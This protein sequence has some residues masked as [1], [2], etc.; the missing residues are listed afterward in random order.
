MMR[1]RAPMLALMS[2]LFPCLALG[3]GPA[4]NPLDAARSRYA[5]LDGIRVHYKSVGDSETALVFIHGWTCNLTFWR[6]QVPAFEGK[7]RMILIDLP[8][9]G[10]SDKPE[11][12]YTMDLFARS[13]DAVLRDAGVEKAVLIGHSMGTPVARQFYRLFPKK[14]VALVAV[15]GPLRPPANM[16]PAYVD[17]FVARYYASKF[18]ESVS[19]VVD[20]MF[21]KETSADVRDAVRSAMQSTPPHVAQ[22]AMRA[23]YDPAIW[24]ESKIPVP[25]QAIVANKRQ[26]GSPDYEKYVR[27]LCPN[28]D[29]VVIDGVGHFLMLDKPD[30][31]NKTL[32]GFL[33]KQGVLKS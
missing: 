14:T 10:Q 4:A 33:A 31:F 19:K 6:T 32:A 5:K 22:S 11:I 13:V 8:G 2:L 20:S 3:A 30:V 28:V 24:E 9:H 16:K 15:D 17:Q 23:M 25:V 12:N 21:P 7:I 26:F 1:E 18:K 29:F 27:K